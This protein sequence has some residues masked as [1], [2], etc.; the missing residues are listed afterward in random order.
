MKAYHVPITTVRFESIMDVNWDLTMQRIVPYIDGIN[1]VRR[2]SELADADYTLTKK[3]ISELLY[4]GCLI[5]VD[6][7]RFANVYA[8]SSE[9]GDF[10][11][12]GKEE[13]EECQNYIS[14]S[15]KITDFPRIVEMY[16]T[17]RQG[18]SVADWSLE[19]RDKLRD[20]DVRRFIQFG[21]I[22]GFLYR[23]QRYPVRVEES[24]RAMVISDPATNNAVGAANGNGNGTGGGLEGLLGRAKSQGTGSG[25]LLQDRSLP[26]L[27]YLDGA[28]HFDSI[29]T[30]LERSEKEVMKNLSAYSIEII[31]R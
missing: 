22:K 14:N 9:I 1:S 28:H 29:C 27:R 13:M 5:L 20:I 31:D 16:S 12:A 25:L 30:D 10:I 4:Y 3:C 2:I 18:L 17:L 21:V 24:M 8:I 7:F 11:A 6:V 19:Y 15:G 23:V 26:L